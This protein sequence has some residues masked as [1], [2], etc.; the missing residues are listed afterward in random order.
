MADRNKDN[1]TVPLDPSRSRKK[2]RSPLP[3]GQK[4]SVAQFPE[5]GREGRNIPAVD[6]EY[7]SGTSAA[8]LLKS[9]WLGRLL[10]LLSLLAVVGSIVWASWTQVDV[11]TRGDGKVVPSSRLQLVQNRKEGVLETLRVREG[12]RVE[13]G[14]IVMTLNEKIL[15]LSLN[16]S[17][18]E[19][20]SLLATIARLKAH[21]DDK[22]LIFP[23]VITEYADIQRREMKL[24]NQQQERL[25]TEMENLGEKVRQSERDV[26]AMESR[27]DHLKRSYN[28]GMKELLMTR[29]LASKGIVSKAEL[30]QLEQ[31]ISDLLSE[32]NEAERNLPYL[33]S[34][35]QEQR[36]REREF[37][38]KFRAEPQKALQDLEVKLARLNESRQDQVDRRE[39]R[40]PLAGI[41]KRVYV[42]TVGSV[43][44]PGMELIEIAPAED[45]LLVAAK[46]DARALALL[47]IGSRAL[48]KLTASDFASYGGLEGVVDH[49]SAD[50]V[51]EEENN[52]FY[53]VRIR[54]DKNYP[55]SDQQPLDIA[56]G[57]RAQVGIVTGRQ[58][59]LS[60]LLESISPPSPRKEQ[61]GG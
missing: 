31:R 13:Q 23:N 33:L 35:L 15:A 3:K 46:I 42:T 56:P 58:T 20:S 18:V 40:A 45:T 7:M 21:A 16:E 61:G 10:I 48:V 28:L 57:M 29:P 54:I 32:L 43:I 50:A 30:I 12:D 2:S 44:Q 17:D 5:G 47:Q 26:R 22:D 36:S 25:E 11:I 38:L 51:T 34:T 27:R 19:Y 14:Q 4:A 39:V 59:V 49:I 9:P 24:Y 1:K 41:V 60:H 37:D 6:L 53:L 52:S 8:L 55:G